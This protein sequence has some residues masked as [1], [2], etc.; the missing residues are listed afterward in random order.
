[1]SLAFGFLMPFIFL[2]VSALFLVHNNVGLHQ[3]GSNYFLLFYNNILL[4]YATIHNKGT[5]NTAESVSVEVLLQNA[6]NTLE[7]ITSDLPLKEPLEISTSA[8]GRL[9]YDVRYLRHDHN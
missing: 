4:H 1:M 3:E 9:L 7:A 6:A 2:C 5:N 8:M